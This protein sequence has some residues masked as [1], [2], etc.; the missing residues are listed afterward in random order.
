MATSLLSD[1]PPAS[2]HTK[3]HHQQSLT[4]SL[5]HDQLIGL[6]DCIG[7]EIHVLSGHLWITQED[8]YR[9]IIIDRGKCFRIDRGGLT[10]M[11]ATQAS[12]LRI[13]I[14]GGNLLSRLRFD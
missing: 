7:A 12:T 14:I 8:D 9:D 4:V 11:S 3:V 13:K 5:Q 2:T 6:E 1:A 10:L